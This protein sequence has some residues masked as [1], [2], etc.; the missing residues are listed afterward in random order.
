MPGM[1]QGISQPAVLGVEKGLGGG[2]ARGK[3]E[4]TNLGHYCN[5]HSGL[6]ITNK[7][8]YH[9]PSKG[10]PLRESELSHILPPATVYRNS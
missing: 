1:W 6:H 8:C 10:K 9:H 3:I 5:L 2:E 4:I 7:R